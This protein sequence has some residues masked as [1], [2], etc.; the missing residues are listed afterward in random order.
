MRQTFTAFFEHVEADP[1]RDGL[2]AVF[3][4]D[5]RPSRVSVRSV[6]MSSPSP[7][8][9][10]G[11][12]GKWDIVRTS[13]QSGG[14][15]V[16]VARHNGGSSLPAQVSVVEYPESVT[17]TDTFRRQSDCV[18]AWWSQAFQPGARLFGQPGR[19]GAELYWAGR[20]SVAQGLFL[21]EGEGIAIVQR[22]IERPRQFYAAITFRK[23]N[24]QTFTAHCHC[25]TPSQV[26]GATIA[27]FN[28]AG[29]GVTLEITSIHFAEEGSTEPPIYRLVM[30][31]GYDAGGTEIAPVGHTSRTPPAGIKCIAGAFRA[32][33]YGE[34]SAGVPIS[35]HTTGPASFAL[36]AQ[37]R[38]GTLRR[39][40]LGPLNPSNYYMGDQTLLYQSPPGEDG[41]ILP[42]GAGLGIVNMSDVRNDSAYAY[43]N[44]EIVFTYEPPVGVSAGR[45][46]G[47]V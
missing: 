37:H 4:F 25:G 11:T 19:S 46:I 47:G 42:P 23:S 18:N 7:W 26:D 16:A 44:V 33:P 13:A 17:V 14:T 35:W 43:A 6:R 29:S 31:D 2:A 41:I 12:S 32:A 9:T 24:G 22:A 36:T 45:V 34:R 39:K 27:I 15:P 10:S 20:G 21:A 5:D 3:N 28:G 40:A 38:V 1:L 8:G 30:L